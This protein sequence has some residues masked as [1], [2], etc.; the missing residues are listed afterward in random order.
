MPKPRTVTEQAQADARD[1]L[2]FTN[3]A[4][5]ENVDEEKDDDDEEEAGTKGADE[6]MATV[7]MKLATFCPN[8]QITSRISLY[9]M[10]VNRLLGEAYLF[11]NFHTLR[12]MDNPVYVK[13]NVGNDGVVSLSLNVISTKIDRNFFYRCLNAVARSNC[14]DGTLADMEESIVEFDKLRPSDQTKVELNG[15]FN[16][17]LGPLSIEMATMAKNHL[18]MN[19]HRRLI[20][21]LRCRFRT[22]KKFHKKIAN[23][24]LFNAKADAAK[25]LGFAKSWHEVS[26]IQY[27]LSTTCAFVYE[28]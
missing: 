6:Y 5:D 27:C 24:V 26:R 1:D 4:K 14:V 17:I 19:L 2:S 12:A 15:E 10:D 9:V 18:W 13:L 28:C 16:E 7:K 25:S 20:G 22:L 8:T 3:R 21:Y 11:A 23:L